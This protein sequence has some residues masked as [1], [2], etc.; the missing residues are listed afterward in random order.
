VLCIN[1]CRFIFSM[2]TLTADGALGS[3]P[4]PAFDNSGGN[5]E[6]LKSPPK[7]QQLFD[8]QICTK[9]G[10]FCNIFDMES[11]EEER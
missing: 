2:K 11:G 1:N 5:F 6:A 9:F 4:P 8:I 7:G 3:Y 10:H